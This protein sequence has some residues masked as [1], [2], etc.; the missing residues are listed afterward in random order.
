MILMKGKNLLLG[1]SVIR[2]AKCS[3]MI[4]FMF[5]MWKKKHKTGGKNGAVSEKS[6]NQSYGE[7]KLKYLE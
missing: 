1:W 5:C 7:L 2:M 3:R 4:Q 6:L